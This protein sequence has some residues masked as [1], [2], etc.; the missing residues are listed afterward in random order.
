MVHIIVFLYPS[1]IRQ[2][3]LGRSSNR[4]VTGNP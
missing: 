3:Y 1:P 4:A 2:A